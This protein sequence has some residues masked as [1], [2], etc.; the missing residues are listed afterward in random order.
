[1]K[2]LA[3]THELVNPPTDDVLCYAMPYL[4]EDS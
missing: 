3:T 1:M 2:C 4:V